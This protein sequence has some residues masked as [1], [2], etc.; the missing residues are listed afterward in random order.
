MAAVIAGMTM[1]SSGG[2]LEKRT[3]ESKAHVAT[4]KIEWEAP[5]L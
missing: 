4:V 5:L 1:R 3:Y 2:Y